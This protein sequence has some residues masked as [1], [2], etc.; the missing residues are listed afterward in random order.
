MFFVD[1]RYRSEFCFITCFLWI[2]GT[3]LSLVLL[4]VFLDKRHPS[5][6]VIFTFFLLLKKHW[7]EFCG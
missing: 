1:K 3:V 2:E 5:Q 4:Q 7:P 6:F